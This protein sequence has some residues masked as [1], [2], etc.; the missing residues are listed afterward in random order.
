MT[1]HHHFRRN[2]RSFPLQTLRTTMG[3]GGLSSIAL[4]RIAGGLLSRRRPYLERS[5]QQRIS[6]AE[7]IS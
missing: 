4:P 7:I 1:L 3:L 6:L 2:L 5:S